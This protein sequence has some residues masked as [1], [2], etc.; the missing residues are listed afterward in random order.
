M[1][2]TATA[3]K[4]SCTLILQATLYIYDMSI[5]FNKLG[6]E[7]SAVQPPPPHSPFPTV[8]NLPTS[9]NKTQFL[10]PSTRLA[11]NILDSFVLFGGIAARK[12]LE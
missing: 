1:N 11:N 9:V 2:L 5:L 7:T 3:K 8:T 12:Q 10:T 6:F 4:Q